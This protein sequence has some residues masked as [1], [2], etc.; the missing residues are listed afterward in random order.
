M[1]ANEILHEI[2][3]DGDIEL[4]LRNPNAPSAVWVQH[5]YKTPKPSSNS[6]V[7]PEKKRKHSA[8]FGSDP[9]FFASLDPGKSVISLDPGKPVMSRLRIPDQYEIPPKKKLSFTLIAWKN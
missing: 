9:D 4:I 7:P 8:A 2:D 1:E 3:P 5:Q 6:T